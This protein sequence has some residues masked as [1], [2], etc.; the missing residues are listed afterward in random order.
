MECIV[1]LFVSL[2][3]IHFIYVQFI[4]FPGTSS[5]KEDNMRLEEKFEELKVE[6]TAEANVEEAGKSTDENLSSD[7]PVDKGADKPVE[8]LAEKPVE[9]PADKPT[10]ESADKPE[11]DNDPQ[12]SNFEDVD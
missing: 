8:E 12:V 9:E 5:A 7:K 2:H 6:A 4:L 1:F 3:S 11:A 10:S